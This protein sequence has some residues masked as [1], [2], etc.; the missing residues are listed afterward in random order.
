MRWQFILWAILM[1]SAGCKSVDADSGRLASDGQV[2]Y[3]SDLRSVGLDTSNLPVG[4]HTLTFRAYANN[5]GPSQAWTPANSLALTAEIAAVKTK[6]DLAAVPTTVKIVPVAGHKDQVDVSVTLELNGPGTWQV[7]LPKACYDYKAMGM[8]GPESF[9]LDVPLPAPSGA[10]RPDAIGCVATAVLTVGPCP[11]IAFSYLASSSVGST[12]GDQWRVVWSEPVPEKASLAS[13]IAAVHVSSSGAVQ[14]SDAVAVTQE[15]ASSWHATIQK[16]PDASYDGFWPFSLEDGVATAFIRGEV[17]SFSCTA[18]AG[19]ALV[20]RV[21]SN[22]ETMQGDIPHV[23]R[24]YLATALASKLGSA[25]AP[26][27]GAP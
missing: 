26:K 17:E 20:A 14:P 2:P 6:P 27:S 8:N 3:F 10:L 23:Q 9:H 1:F 19:K 5:F 21:D 7:D 4:P 18:A 12:G 24:G 16:K 11:H 22:G 15:S 25:K 13:K